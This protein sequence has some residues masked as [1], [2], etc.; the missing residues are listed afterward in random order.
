MHVSDFS[1]SGLLR[2]IEGASSVDRV[3]T[4]YLRLRLGQVG[5]LELYSKKKAVEVVRQ[6]GENAGR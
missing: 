3:R 6:V 5:I 2:R 4:V 1:F